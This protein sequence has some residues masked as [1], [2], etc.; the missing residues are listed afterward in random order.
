VKKLLVILVLAVSFL[1]MA[2]SA[3]AAYVNG[4]YKSS[5]AYVQPYYRS[6]PNGL[7]Y[8]N[9][10]YKPSQPLY[11]NSYGAYNTYKWN[12]PTYIT[13][14]SYN[15]GLNSYNSYHSAYSY[16][17]YSYGSLYKY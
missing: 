4:Y 16:P 5:G 8:D 1:L 6:N 15:Y 13:Q 12:T 3:N 10:G 14:P 9:Y 7:L 2:K 11:N 17:S